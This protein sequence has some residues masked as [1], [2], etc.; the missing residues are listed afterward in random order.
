VDSERPRLHYGL[1]TLC[2]ALAYTMAYGP[3]ALRM[4]SARVFSL[5]LL[6]NSDYPLGYPCASQTQTQT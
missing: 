6:A 3:C 1:L 4:R 5:G 2:P